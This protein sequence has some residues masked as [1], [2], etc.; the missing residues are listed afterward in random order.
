MLGIDPETI[1][2][3]AA[4]FKRIAAAFDE[5]QKA[6]KCIEIRLN[7]IEIIVADTAKISD[8]VA[9]IAMEIRNVIIP[10]SVAETSESSDSRGDND[11]A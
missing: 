9:D 3:Y 6:V 11:A 10:D 4:D 8:E 2:G 7:A 5:L 1:S